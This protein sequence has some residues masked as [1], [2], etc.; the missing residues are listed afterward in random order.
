MFKELNPLLHSEL[1]LAVI[2]LLMTVE[3]A[4]F[5]YLRQQTGATAGNLSIQIDKLN[6][7]GYVDVTKTFK[8]KMPRTVCKITPVGVDA[9]EEYVEAL[10]TYILR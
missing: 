8:G 7:A 6:N 10:K 2:S 9:F 3:E 1:R 4:D 5:V